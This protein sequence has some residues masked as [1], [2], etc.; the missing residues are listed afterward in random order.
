[1][2]I[3][4][5]IAKIIAFIAI[6]MLCFFQVQKRNA[7]R[8]LIQERQ[9]ALKA[10]NHPLSKVVFQLPIYRDTVY[11]VYLVKETSK[12][13][14]VFLKKG[15]ITDKQRESSFFVHI[16]PKDKKKLDEGINHIPNNFK[17]NVTSFVFNS[18]NY[19]V[20]ETDMPDLKISKLN[21]GQFGF[22]GD[23][24]V[25]WQT[26]SLLDHEHMQRIVKENKE[27][28]PLFSVNQVS[29]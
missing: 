19:Y 22:R 11:R 9:L 14:L 2:I 13:K 4:N 25:S 5:K 27:D 3:F 23:N 24:S 21:L 26:S 15:C 12:N 1:M 28:V 7:Q 10:A 20:S 17:N 29:F 8:N 6:G 18:E 16:Y